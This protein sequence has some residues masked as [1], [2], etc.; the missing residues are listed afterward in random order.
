MCVQYYWNVSFRISR[1][2]FNK[3][4]GFCCKCVL[5]FKRP[6]AYYH[7]S[8]SYPILYSTSHTQNE[9]YETYICENI[10]DNIRYVW[11]INLNF[12]SISVPKYTTGIKYTRPKIRLLSTYVCA[13]PKWVGRKSKNNTNVKFCCCTNDAK[14]MYYIRVQHYNVQ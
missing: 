1:N 4:I 2:I 7:V 10:N 14:N 3:R 6:K 13:N 12:V 5:S 9:L 8:A 11:N